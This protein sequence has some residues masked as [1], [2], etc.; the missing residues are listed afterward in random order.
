MASAPC[1]NRE[2]C[3]PVSLFD[4]STWY[5]QPCLLRV[6]CHN[7]SNGCADRHVVEVSVAVTA[8][9]GAVV[10]FDFDEGSYGG[11]GLVSDYSLPSPVYFGF[12]GRTGGATNNQ[13]AIY[14]CLL[15]T[16]ILTKYHCCCSWVKEINYGGAWVFPPPPPPPPPLPNFINPAA[17]ALSGSTQVVG[18]TIQLVR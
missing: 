9:G 8:G 15:Q 4:D 18:E 7:I 1:H 14:D 6:A 12:S 5:A 2:G 3:I 10:S 13:Y 11:F 16:I 17:F